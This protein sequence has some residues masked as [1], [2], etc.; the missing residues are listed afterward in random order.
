MGP[1][2]RLIVRVLA[3]VW[4]SPYT[5]LG[6][7]IGGVGLCTGGRMQVRSGIIEFYGGAV[8]WLL[9]RLPGG[10]LT[11]AMTLGHSVLGQSR[12]AL[13]ICRDHELVHV[14]QYQRWGPLMGPAYLLCSLVLWLRGRRPY[15]DNPF[16][17]E[18]YGDSHPRH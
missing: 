4:A 8:R 13:D 14:R 9:R 18:A 10:E 3:V 6:I 7:L 2:L 17:R 16:E 1:W 15:R 5:L 11:L 12:T